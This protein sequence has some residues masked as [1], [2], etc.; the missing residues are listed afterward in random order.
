[1]RNATSRDDLRIQGL[2]L[3]NAADGTTFI[4]NLT[5]DTKFE[6]NDIQHYLALIVYIFIFL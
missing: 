2:N 4:F 6:V 5:Y 1:M 3:F